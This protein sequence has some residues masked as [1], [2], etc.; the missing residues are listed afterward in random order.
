[1]IN[2]ICGTVKMLQVCIHAYKYCFY[3]F[4]LFTTSLISTLYNAQNM[5]ENQLF[6]KGN[7]NINWSHTWGLTALLSLGTSSTRASFNTEN[8]EENKTAI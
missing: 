2:I 1:M 8:K 4:Y 6:Q 7:E 3:E 5:M